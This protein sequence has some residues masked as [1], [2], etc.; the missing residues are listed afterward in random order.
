MKRTLKIAAP[1]GIPLRLHWTFGLVF[2]YIFFIAWEGRWDWQVTLMALGL[3][4][5][6][7][8]CVT[9]HEYGHALMARRFGVSTQDIL[10]SPIGGIARLD[11]IPSRPKEEFLVAVAGPAVNLVLAALFGV[12]LFTFPAYLR[13][14]LL[15]S[16]FFRESN[17]FLPELPLLG[18]AFLMLFFLNII[19]A[20]FN[21]IPAFPMDGGRIL[22]AVLSTRL[23]RY[24]A[25]LIAARIGQAFAVVFAALGV[26]LAVRSGGREGIF[27]VFISIFV[28]MTA[29]NELRFVAMQTQIENILDAGTEALQ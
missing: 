3:V 21:L 9:L 24:T 20:V 10:L 17:Y 7:F 8:V 2:L 6:L 5:S 15:Q 4:V 1:F 22:R 13:W 27:Y 16:L 11:R 29:Q 28:F 12:Y 26:F 25:T 14:N 23:P 19:L 18:Y